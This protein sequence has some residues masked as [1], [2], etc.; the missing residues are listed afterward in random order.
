MVHE[1]KENIQ[2]PVVDVPPDGV[3]RGAL[4]RLAAISLCALK[5]VHGLGEIHVAVDQH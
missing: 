5:P 2:L 4:P 1:I 3:H